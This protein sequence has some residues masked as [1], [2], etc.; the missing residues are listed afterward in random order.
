MWAL[1]QQRGIFVAAACGVVLLTIGMAEAAIIARSQV[2]FSGVQGQ[3][4]WRYG[5]YDRSADSGNPNPADDG[6][7]QAGD[8]EEF[9]TDG[10]FP[11]FGFIGGSWDW[12]GTEGEPVNPPWTE[13]FASG[14]HPNLT[15]QIAVLTMGYDKR[16]I[17]ALHNPVQSVQKALQLTLI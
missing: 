6:T 17:H 16:P 7:Y 1:L 11:R 5:Y 14:G 8:F 15:Q 10:P 9:P 3:D 2:E 13:L 4:N 12:I